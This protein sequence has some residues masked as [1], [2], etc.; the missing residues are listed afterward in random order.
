[1]TTTKLPP[2]S[3]GDR[4]LINKPPLHLSQPGQVRW[5]LAGNW[6]AVI[7]DSDNSRPLVFHAT[8]LVAEEEE[9][10]A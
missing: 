7:R 9:E 4:V 1:M 8:E 3:R 5:C 10:A 2:F 6:Y